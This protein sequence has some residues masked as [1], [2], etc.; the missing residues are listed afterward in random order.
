MLCQ[1]V[2]NID[3]LGGHSE[4][5]V[6]GIL[7]HFQIDLRDTRVIQCGGVG[8]HT[9]AVQMALAIV[10]CDHTAQLNDGKQIQRKICQNGVAFIDVGD[11]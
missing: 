3:L 8:V 6:D 4:N 2:I 7:L 5:D 11:G 1:F 10:W 9:T